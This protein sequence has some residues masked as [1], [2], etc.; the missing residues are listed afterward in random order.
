MR[1][2]LLICPEPSRTEALSDVERE[3]A[4]AEYF[5]L[6]GGGLPGRVGRRNGDF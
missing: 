1:Y 6:A 5:A 2:A 3:A 4:Y